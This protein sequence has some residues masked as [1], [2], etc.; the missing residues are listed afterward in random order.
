MRF[1]DQDKASYDTLDDE[2]FKKATL[3]GW[4]RIPGGTDHAFPQFKLPASSSKEVK[5]DFVYNILGAAEEERSKIMQLLLIASGQKAP[6]TPKTITYIYKDQLSITLKD[7]QREIKNNSFKPMKNQN[8]I[9]VYNLKDQS[10]Y[11]NISEKLELLSKIE[12]SKFILV[13]VH[14]ALESKHLS[15]AE[16]E[17]KALAKQYHAQ[18]VI[19]DLKTR[20]CIQPL[21]QRIERPCEALKRTHDQEK[22]DLPFVNTIAKQ[23]IY[24]THLEAQKYWR[25]WRIVGV[26][27]AFFLLTP[28]S[29]I[30]TLP[31]FFRAQKNDSIK[32]LDITID[33][34][35][36]V[37]QKRKAWYAAIQEQLNEEGLTIDSKPI[38]PKKIL[39]DSGFDEGNFHL[40]MDRAQYERF[41]LFEEHDLAYLKANVTLEQIE[42]SKAESLA[43][44]RG[45][46]LTM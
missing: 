17:L 7:K 11:L 10:Q 46:E 30:A 27:V 41:K 44:M 12:G 40:Y 28:L 6:N 8:Y 18:S 36:E 26:V 39:D 45:L 38:K 5:K 14:S 21:K 42:Q 43:I 20:N 9:L 13:G 29:L 15:E 35:Q 37:K 3:Q 4:K 31:L 23:P 1:I 33:K 25:N 24:F 34:Y 19:I 22:N 2:A 32:E 16:S